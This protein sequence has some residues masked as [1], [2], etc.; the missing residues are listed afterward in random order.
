MTKRKTI[1]KKL[2]FDVFKR[3]LFC[4]QYCGD[5]PPNVVLEV[6][7]IEPVCEGGN[8][9]IDN[10]ITAC[11]ECNRGKSGAPLSSI[12]ESLSAKAERIKESEWQLLQYRKVISAKQSRIDSDAWEVIRQIFGENTNSIRKDYFLQVKRFNEMLGLEVCI[13][14]GEI[15]Y[16]APSMATAS[17]ERVWKYFCAVCWRKHNEA[18]NG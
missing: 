14:A 3:D 16:C 17:D 2:R 10:L 12:P 18:K 4:C 1:S 5:V 13:E 9:D 8:N 15:A 6:D 7:R 11:F